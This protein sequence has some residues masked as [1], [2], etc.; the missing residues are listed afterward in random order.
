MDKSPTTPAGGI[1]RRLSNFRKSAPRIR[2]RMSKKL[3]SS[4][5][6][7]QEITEIFQIKETHIPSKPCSVLQIREYIKTDE[8]KKAY[9]NLLS[10]RLDIEQKRGALEEGASDVDLVNKETDISMLF[11]TLKNKIADIVRSSTLPSINKELLG[12]VV[13]IV[14]EEKKK[15]E[16]MMGWMEMLRNAVR[17]GVRD[18]LKKVPLDKPEQNTS[19]LAVHL[20]LLGKAIE[21]DLKRVTSELLS[22]YPKDFNVF[23]TYVSCYHEVAE[24][25]LKEILEKVTDAKDYKTLLDFIIRSC[26]GD[27][28]TDQGAVTLDQDFLKKIK[29]AYCDRLMENFKAELENI[30]NL[31]RD[32]VWKMKKTPN[33]TDEGFLT[34]QFNMEI[35]QMTASYAQQLKEIDEDHGKMFVRFSLEEIHEFHKRFEE[36]FREHT[37]SLLTSD[38]LDL[39]LWVNYHITYIN[40]F[41]LL[42]EQMQCYRESCLTQVVQLEKDMD[43]VTQ[44]L[45]QTLME[46]FKTDIKPYINGMMTKKWI[47]TDEDFTEVTSRIESYSGLCKS[48][49]KPASQSFVNDVHYYVIKEYVSQLMKKK[50][51]CKNSKN[52][53]AADK[54]RTQWK[55]LR[56]LFEEMGSSLDWLYPLGNYLSD[57]IGMENEKSIK[58]ILHPLVSDYPDISKKQM[59]AV[60]YFRDNGFSLERHQVINQFNLLKRDTA[61]IIHEHSFFIDMK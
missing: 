29:S 58:D 45:R 44:R 32:K 10:L 34:S 8:L 40:T 52:E 6:K 53:E 14:L 20:G 51:S 13:T 36:E 21:D 50:F 27:L 39:Y 9:V 7:E 3:S 1:F 42:K 55:E 26:P 41:L 4:F 47:K 23:E 35:C 57:I 56:K 46:H 17:D 22:S 16:M 19:W 38:L 15:S 11:D 31:E 37:R 30:I 49:R 25:H 59:S 33:T 54:M 61:N 2:R 28:R 5:D 48:M 24:E 60:L 12:Q 43:E 18:S